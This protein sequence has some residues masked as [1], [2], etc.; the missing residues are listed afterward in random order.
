MLEMKSVALLSL[1][2]GSRRY[3][4]SLYLRRLNTGA[5]PPR[6]VSDRDR[7]LRTIPPVRPSTRQPLQA[8]DP[9]M[10]FTLLEKGL[11]RSNAAATANSAE[12]NYG[13]QGSLLPNFGDNQHISI[14]KEL[15]AELCALLTHFRAPIDFAFGYGSGVFQQSGYNSGGSAPQTDLILAVSDSTAFHTLNMRQNPSHYSGLR[16]FGPQV[17][18][19]FQHIGAGVYFNPFVELQGR[20][21][22]YGIVCMEDLLRDLATWDKFYLAGRLQKPVKIL[23]ADPRVT[24][25][26]QKNLHAAATLG[27]AL[28]EQR[29]GGQFNEFEL[30]RE[31]AGLSYLGDIRYTLG[32]ENPHKVDNI[33]SRNF[34]QFQ[35]YY[36]PIVRDIKAGTAQQY[37]PPGYSLTNATRLLERKIRKVSV[38]QTL[39]GILTAGAVK[40]VKYAWSKKVKAWGRRR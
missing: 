10:D 25:W 38:L 11:Q 26:N 2:R 7:I 15:D 27:R 14:D 20:Q 35:L 40:S 4:R 28:A 3:W 39:K 34:D 16:W 18:S 36:G 17:V 22:K 33:V 13:F 1:R 12:Y 5:E 19:R 24:Y 30:Y 6:G 37:L 21:V 23:R 32:G 8:E 31:I 29:H 9:P